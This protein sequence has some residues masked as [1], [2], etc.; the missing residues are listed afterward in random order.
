[1]L[2][3]IVGIIMLLGAYVP[4]AAH[5]S[6][7][8]DNAFPGTIWSGS[9]GVNNKDG[10]RFGDSGGTLEIVIDRAD[11]KTGPQLDQ[12]F[13]NVYTAV[14]SLTNRVSA[15]TALVQLGVAIAA[16]EIQG[17]PSRTT[18]DALTKQVSVGADSSGD[19]IVRVR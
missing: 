19:L 13:Q 5:L 6:S 8:A 1:M 4:S 7:V 2:S 18:L 16:I 14:A 3:V 12:N 17:N 11:Q 15:S 9:S 10:V